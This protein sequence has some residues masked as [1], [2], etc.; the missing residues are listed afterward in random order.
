MATVSG[1]APNLQID[2]KKTGR[3]TV[4]IILENPNY[5]DVA[6]KTAT[7]NA[8]LPTF[9]FTALT[10]DYYSGKPI[11]TAQ[12][13][14]QING[15]T[16]KGYRLKSITNISD[17]TVATVSGTAPNLQ[18]DLKKTGRF[19]ADIMLENPNYFDVAIQG[20]FVAGNFGF[21]YLKVNAM[22]VLSLKSGTDKSKIVR[23]NIPTT[24]QR[25]NRNG[26][27]E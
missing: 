26:Y 13:L 24:I 7:V 15:A 6:I 11:T 19:T 10:R 9:A 12:I 20:A 18:I 23:I 14:A 27:W 17:A 1:T 4:D 8:T 21:K 22:G 3:F 16:A 2:L 25:Y 5:F